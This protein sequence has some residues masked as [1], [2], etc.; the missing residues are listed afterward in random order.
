V[1]WG[2][3]ARGAGGD[4]RADV[5]GQFGMGEVDAAEGIADAAGDGVAGA[6][7]GSP[8]RRV[9]QVSIPVGS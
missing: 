1:F 8:R 3:A 6:L 9:R 2:E 4:R 5:I 7:S